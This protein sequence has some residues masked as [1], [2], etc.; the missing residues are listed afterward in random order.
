MQDEIDLQ[1][2][3][4][5]STEEPE[6]AGLLEM[7]EEAFPL[8]E[9]APTPYTIN[10]FVSGTSRWFVGIMDQEVVSFAIIYRMR[11]AQ[12]LLLDYYAVKNGFR[13][14]G[15]GTYFL[16]HLFQLLNISPQKEKIILE[17][18]D[19]DCGKNDED[20]NI[21]V[22]RVGFY[23]NLGITQIK[24]VKYFLPSWGDYD[25]I[26]MILMVY[27]IPDPETFT[28]KKLKELITEFYLDKYHRD[29]EEPLLQKML[30]SVP[31]ELEYI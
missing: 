9:R 11:T 10:H 12:M 16:S 6:V 27:P 8:G 29:P 5:D 17:V 22:K 21:R 2:K 18:D 1:I 4:I 7:Y 14:K 19:P 23:R 24:D 13:G 25:P 28:T 31:A 26:E 20:T 3:E 15:I 30:D